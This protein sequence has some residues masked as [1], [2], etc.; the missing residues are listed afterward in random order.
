MAHNSI[1]E[2]DDNLLIAKITK[3]LDYL[4]HSERKDYYECG[5]PEDHIF[6]TIKS[7]RDDFGL[8]EFYKN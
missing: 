4:W 6:S 3:L 5:C 7:L 2:Y 1:L 8:T